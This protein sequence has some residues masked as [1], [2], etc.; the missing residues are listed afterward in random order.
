VSAILCALSPV[1]SA[2]TLI[3]SDLRGG[4][5][6]W[7]WCAVNRGTEVDVY[8]YVLAG[9]RRGVLPFEV[10]HPPVTADEIIFSGERLGMRSGRSLQFFDT[11]ASFRHLPQFDFQVPAG[12]NELLLTGDRL[13]V[14]TGRTVR[15]YNISANYRPLPKYDFT[16]PQGTDE[17][18]IVEN[19]LGTW[20]G[21]R[22]GTQLQFYNI[23]RGYK[24][25]PKYLFS[26]P[27][28][29]DEVTVSG[30]L[31]LVMCGDRV[32]VYD[33]ERQAMDKPRIVVQIK[34]PA[35]PPLETL[36]GRAFVNVTGSDEEHLFEFWA[37]GN[38][39]R[40]EEVRDGKKIVTIQYGDTLYSYTEGEGLATTGW[41][42][43]GLTSLGF[44]NQMSEVKAHGERGESKEI[45]G[46]QYHQYVY[47]ENA[48]EE[49]VVGYLSATN[50]LPGIW[51]LAELEDDG[52]VIQRTAAFRD[53]EAN[54]AIPDKLFHLPRGLTFQK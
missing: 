43:N 7:A 35:V 15:F 12:T 26:L 24:P 21:V 2:H 53:L 32:E 52:R 18:A 27:D 29:T 44:I 38:R 14:R 4:V 51:T 28:G 54:V 25:N 23:D 31:L 34:E 49:V 50:S 39:L 1:G 11:T 17:L 19:S 45:D 36:H 40:T 33:F 16:V 6:P 3:A 46:V 30:P 48:P 22:I 37:K 42:G 8:R 9:S 10:F 20:L 13:G 5:H 41:L 47:R